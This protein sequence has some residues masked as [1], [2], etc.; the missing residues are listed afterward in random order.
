MPDVNLPT[1]TG[2]TPLHAAANM[3]RLDLVNRLLEYPQTNP[4]VRIEKCDGSTPLH[5]AVMHGNSSIVRS[6]LKAG[7]DAT[8]RMGEDTPLK[9]ATALD[10]QDVIKVFKSFGVEK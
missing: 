5:I 9:L 8:L 7:A 3:A 4:N 6:L 10:H 1:S 2:N